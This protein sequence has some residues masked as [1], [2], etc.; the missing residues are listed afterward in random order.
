MIVRVLVREGREPHLL[1]LVL[2]F[3]SPCRFAHRLNC[4]QQSAT[5]IPIMAMTT[6]N[7]TNVKPHNGFTLPKG[8]CVHDMHLAFLATVHRIMKLVRVE[9]FHGFWRLHL[10]VHR[11]SIAAR[12]EAPLH[13]LYT[14]LM[15]CGK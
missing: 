13:H 10:D 12:R 14:K 1:E 6:S 7:S 8:R 11:S 9:S 2:A 15:G 3:G 4:R 5:R